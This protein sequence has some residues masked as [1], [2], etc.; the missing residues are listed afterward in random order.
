MGK[1]IGFQRRKWTIFARTFRTEWCSRSWIP[2]VSGFVVPVSGV[3][4]TVPQSRA[5][6]GTVLCNR[7]T[8][9][10]SQHE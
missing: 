2:T 6:A 1:R 5:H 7:T 8:I 4:H 3:I 10:G 9:P